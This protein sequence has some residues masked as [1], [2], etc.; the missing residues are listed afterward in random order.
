MAQENPAKEAQ[1][2][3]ERASN[4]SRR[5]GEAA[6]DEMRGMKEEAGSRMDAAKDWIHDAAD[7]RMRATTDSGAEQ[8]ERTARAFEDAAGEYRE[9]SMPR[10]ALHRVSGFLEDTARD[11]RDTDLDT[12]T[13]EVSRFARRNPVLFV[14]GAAAVGFAAAR[15]LR[16]GDIDDDD[17]DDTWDAEGPSRP[18]KSQPATRPVPSPSAT[19]RPATPTGATPGAPPTKTPGA[20]PDTTPGAT[21]DTTHGKTGGAA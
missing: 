9:G 11:L 1:K 18:R 4:E 3:A 21:S 16:A 5:A 6:R 2:V 12:V 20:K 19:S 8:V 13:T 15:L 14:A 17:T 10:E 7:E